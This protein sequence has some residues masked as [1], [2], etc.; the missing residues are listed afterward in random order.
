MSKKRK[1]LEEVFNKYH[2][3]LIDW[4]EIPKVDAI[5][6][7][8]PHKFYLSK[9]LDMIPMF[10]RKCLHGKTLQKTNWY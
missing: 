5:I 2:I 6:L 1:T 10:Q 7:A 9:T 3:G 8:V 4:N